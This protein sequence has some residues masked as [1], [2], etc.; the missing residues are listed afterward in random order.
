MCE[1]IKKSDGYQILISNMLMMF[2]VNAFLTPIMWTMNFTYFLKKFQICMIERKSNA[3][4]KH[5][6]TQRELNELYELPSMSI[7]YKYSY[8]AKTLLMTFLYISIFPLGVVIS[9][10]G[11]ILGYLLEKF[12]YAH[13]YK[14]PEMLNH[15]LCVFYVNHLDVVIFVY[16]IGDYI[17]MH[18]SYENKIIPLTKIIIFGV[19][20]ILPYKKFLKRNYIGMLESDI[21]NAKYK[22]K[23]FTFS[24]DYERANPI[25]RK[26]GIKN[27]LKKMLESGKINKNRYME[28]IRESS[29]FS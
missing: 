14:R 10:V 6:M 27:Y 3:D 17:F 24:M 23:Y 21:S 26:K 7:S 13:M 22:D 11:F 8:L 2:L 1:L 12:N 20:T 4:N 29:T 15:K 28:L 16:A 5:N 18:N 19:L 25:T 9:L